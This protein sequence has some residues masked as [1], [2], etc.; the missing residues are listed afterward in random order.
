VRLTDAVEVFLNL[1][2]LGGG[3]RG[4]DEEEALRE[5]GNGFSSN[6]LDFTTVSLGAAYRLPVSD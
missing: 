5:P 4:T 3:A 6:W 2:Y 1:R